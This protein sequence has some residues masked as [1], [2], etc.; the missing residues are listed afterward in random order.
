MN[1]DQLSSLAEDRSNL[2]GLLGN[3][4]CGCKDGEQEGGLTCRSSALGQ[5]AL[6][7]SAGKARTFLGGL[8]ISTVSV[9]S[10]ADS[11]SVP[12][13]TSCTTVG[14]SLRFRV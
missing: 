2:R 8:D 10:I 14:L 12:T 4:G 11:G 5:G 1:E 6:G 9:K 3:E 13:S 7:G